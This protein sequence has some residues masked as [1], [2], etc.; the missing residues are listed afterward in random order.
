MKL[1][2]LIVG[3]ALNLVCMDLFASDPSNVYRFWS[4]TLATHFYTINEEER[5]SIQSQMGETWTYEGPAWAALANDNYDGALPVYRFWREG[6][7]PHFYT[8]SEDEKNF[9][10]DNFPEWK[11]ERVA[12]YAYATELQ[13]TIPVYRFWNEYK[14]THFYTADEHE[15]NILTENTQGWQYETIAWYAY[16]RDFTEP[17][18][19]RLFAAAGDDWQEVRIPN[20]CQKPNCSKTQVKGNLLEESIKLSTYKLIAG[21][22]PVEI[23]ESSVTASQPGFSGFITGI[24]RGTVLAPGEE[25]VFSLHAYNTNGAEIT[26]TFQV[27]ARNLGNLLIDNYTV[28]T[29]R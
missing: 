1:I 22:E 7:G 24:D 8:I 29:Q 19:V 15:K 25:R 4:D 18:H 26:L 23:T 3:F 13:D 2:T 5:D 27:S 11:Y 17:E 12:Y 9:I 20:I 10:I 16:P 28:V 14:Q 6:A 21:I